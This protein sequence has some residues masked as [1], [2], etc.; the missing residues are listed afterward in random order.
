LPFSMAE[1]LREALRAAGLEVDWLPFAGGHE[2]PPPVLG[3]AS[4]FLARVL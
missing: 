1:D 2:I 4:A 3:G